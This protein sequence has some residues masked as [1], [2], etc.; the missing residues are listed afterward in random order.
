MGI[1][2][3]LIDEIRTSFEVGGSMRI[4]I[5]LSMLMAL[6]FVGLCEIIIKIVAR[7]KFGKEK[8]CNLSVMDSPEKWYK[9]KMKL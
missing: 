6:F 9:H 5:P 1:I 3:A 2:E 8:R 7:K 4:W